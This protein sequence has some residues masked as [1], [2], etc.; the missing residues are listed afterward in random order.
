MCFDGLGQKY[1]DPSIMEG[2]YDKSQGYLS[3]SP[4]DSS[5]DTEV[6]D[7]LCTLLT[8]GRMSSSNREVVKMVYNSLLMEGG[9]ND[10]ALRVAQ[11]LIVTSSEFHTTSLTRSQSSKQDREDSLPKKT[12]KKYKAV[13]HL[14]LGG[15]MD[16]YNMLV[17]HSKCFGHGRNL[18]FTFYSSH[19]GLLFLIGFFYLFTSVLHYYFTLLLLCLSTS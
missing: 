17:P 9:S 14:L 13:V 19:F 10:E 4:P 18:L 6:V 8:S 11:Q 3:Y 15:G 12:C 16:S 5:S 1:C 7:N 2:E